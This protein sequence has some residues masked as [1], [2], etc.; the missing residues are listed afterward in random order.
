MLFGL[1]A[2]TKLY[3]LLFLVALAVLCART[4]Q[5]RAWLRTAVTT[6]LTAAAVGLPV[7]FTA[8][9]FNGTDKVSDGIV[10]TFWSGGD[11][12]SMITGGPEYARNGL[13][14]FFDLNSERPADWDSL[15]FAVTW[16]AGEY[17][18]TA[19]SAVHLLIAVVT[20]AVVAVA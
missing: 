10:S 20:A 5:M 7:W 11:W 8:G 9:Y 6:V 18:V 17:D 19:F 12:L 4:G 14:R 16:F 13:A 1:G 15:A 3:P 2:V